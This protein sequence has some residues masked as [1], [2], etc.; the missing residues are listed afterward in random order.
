MIELCK[1]VVD[2]AYDGTQDTFKVNP[3]GFSKKVIDII[4]GDFAT[5]EACTDQDYRFPEVIYH[6]T[7]A[8]TVSPNSSSFA[9]PALNNTNIDL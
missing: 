1:D 5:F 9:S 8:G 6:G 4:K 2:V 3:V 7:S